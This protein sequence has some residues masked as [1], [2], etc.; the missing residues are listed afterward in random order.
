MGGEPRTSEMGGLGGSVGMMLGASAE[1]PSGIGWYRMLERGVGS[2]K[3]LLWW[4]GNAL[5]GDVAACDIIF[6]CFVLC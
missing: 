3:K 1:D 4:W 2:G 6:G 5:G